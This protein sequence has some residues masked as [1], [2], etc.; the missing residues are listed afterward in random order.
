M[1]TGAQSGGPGRYHILLDQVHIVNNELQAAKV[2]I[3]SFKKENEELVKNFDTCKQQ[4]L[5]TRQK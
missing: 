1:H 5:E 4:L 3:A 2:L